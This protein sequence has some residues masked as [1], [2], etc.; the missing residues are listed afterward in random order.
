MLQEY[1]FPITDNFLSTCRE[2]A[3]SIEV[4]YQYKSKSQLIDTSRIHEHHRRSTEIREIS[5]YWK[6]VKRHIQ[7]FVEIHELDASGE[8]GP[9]E[10]E[11][12]EKILSG[13]IYR[14]KQVYIQK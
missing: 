10:V 2:G 6:D 1:T 13:G 3:I 11:T 5:D 12:E 14:L 4:W 9:V 8:W 7:F